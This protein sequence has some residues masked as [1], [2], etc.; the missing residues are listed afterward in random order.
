MPDSWKKHSVEYQW[1]FRA[2]VKFDQVFTKLIWKNPT[3]YKLS[4]ISDKLYLTFNNQTFLQSGMYQHY[5]L[6]K[7]GVKS[8]FAILVISPRS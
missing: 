8:A 5:S 6:C 1:E 3:V 2:V 7:Q 4:D